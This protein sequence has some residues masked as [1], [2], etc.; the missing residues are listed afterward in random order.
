MLTSNDLFLAGKAALLAT[1]GSPYTEKN[2]DTPG[3]DVNMFLTLVATMGEEVSR[4]GQLQDNAR[5]LGTAPGVGDE[6]VDRLAFDITGGEVVRFEEQ[7]AVAEVVLSRQN[8]YALTLGKDSV[9]SSAAGV[10]YRT[11]QDVSWPTGDSS[12]K[13]VT[14]ICE[15]TGVTG[16]VDAH[17]I[18][19]PPR[20]VGDSTLSVDNPEP[21]AGGRP[22]ETNPELIQRVRGWFIANQ[23]GTLAAIEFG[24]KQVAQVVQA[25]A[26]EVYDTEDVYPVWRVKLTIGD[27]NGQANNALVAL[28][29]TKLQEYRG[30]GVPV[31]IRAGV[32]QYISIAWINLAFK[33]GYS[34]SSVLED[35]FSR[36]VSVVNALAPEETLERALLF[37]AAKATPGLYVPAGSLLTPSTDIV[38]AVGYTIRVRRAD[39]SHTQ[40]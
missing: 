40:T 19:K 13:T 6:A 12:A 21:A 16:N 2:I 37:A 18:T 27:V 11:I 4:E 9:I 7:A 15:T 31:M 8:T 23:R 38:P 39:I 34:A 30:A 29:R 1:P 36:C 20:D 3:S 22:R 5:Y 32:I 14:V 28:V 17:A 24:A 33:I 26:I 35:L 10:T 25:T